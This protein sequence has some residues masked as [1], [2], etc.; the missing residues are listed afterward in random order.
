[1]IVEAPRP[2]ALAHGDHLGRTT[3]IRKLCHHAF[4][5]RDFFC[6]DDTA[7]TEIYTLSLHDALPISLPPCASAIIVR[8]AG[9]P[10]WAGSGWGVIG[11]LDRTADSRSSRTGPLSAGWS[12]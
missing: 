1:M 9:F 7:T 11:A 8:V 2:H 5:C 4:E 12:S 6:F 10:A 3:W